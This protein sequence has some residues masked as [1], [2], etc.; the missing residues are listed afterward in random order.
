MIVSN[1]LTKFVKTVNKLIDPPLQNT[2]YYVI[3]IENQ[4]LYNLKNIHKQ[5]TPIK[6]II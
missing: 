6:T 3:M 1:D 2:T 5:E 4:K